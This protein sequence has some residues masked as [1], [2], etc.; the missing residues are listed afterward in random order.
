[1]QAQLLEHYNR[2]LR[3]LREM[4][5]EFAERYPK[6]AGRLDLGGIECADPYV[7]RL[8]EGFAFLTARIQ[9]K[10]DA[11]FPKFTQHLLEMVYPHYLAPTP[12]MTI[13]QFDPDLKGGVTEEGYLLPRQTE[14]QATTVKGRA[15]CEFRTAHE[16]M[17]WPIRLTSAE[18]LPSGEV[19]EYQK[20]GHGSI[21]SAIRLRLETVADIAFQQL[22]MDSLSLYIQG[23]GD[24][25]SQVYELLLGHCQGVV[26]KP[27]GK[28]KIWQE[29][30]SHQ[31]LQTVGFNDEES[32]LPYGPQS[33]KGY[34][35]LQEY[36]SLPQRFMFIKLAGLQK[37]IQ[38][39]EGTVLEFIVLL[40]AEQDS[41]EDL[42]H[43][44]NFKLNCSPVI[45]LFPKRA[46]RIHLSKR[47]T[48]H[49]LVVD[50]TRPGDYE[51]Y[52]V[53]NVT[54]FG[55]GSDPEQVFHPF[56]SNNNQY[57]GKDFYTLVRKP[58]LLPL[59]Q[60]QP[61]SKAAYAGSEVFIS[62]VDESETTY[63]SDLKQLGVEALCTNKDLPQ[64]LVMGRGKTDFTL[65]IGA[66]VNSVH[67]LTALTNPKP[68]HPDG[69]HAWRLVSHLSLNYLSLMEA[70]D[71][72][73]ALREMLKLYADFSDS[74]IRKQVDG[75]LSVSSRAVVRRM[76]VKGPM[77]FARGVEITVT[78]DDQAFEGTGSFLFAELLEQFFSKYVSINSFTQTIVRT[79][80][81]GEIM[82]WPVRTGIK[83]LI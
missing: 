55:S 48:E 79:R 29:F 80:E 34:R 4:G 41:L 78:L 38:R 66:P 21:K 37:A 11:E 63:R 74:P 57:L 32:L 51:V 64:Y 75:L 67:C 65:E 46:D 49:H 31:T 70:D 42:L 12:S 39:C 69:E 3:Y 71:G 22:S 14:L 40:D 23:S 44:E 6:I 19:A 61:A 26:A 81:R 52:S 77:A 10:L 54:G 35:Y 33:F 1:M 5:K 82:K 8:L 15:R 36:F 20:S 58:S 53:R 73:S 62:L 30:L 2:E 28:K 50:K 60:N 27:P 24:L 25:P 13:V 47:S 68:A 76:P 16:V 9:L 45:N 72:A 17:L 18:Y 56:Y 43:V 59:K 83:T 7:E